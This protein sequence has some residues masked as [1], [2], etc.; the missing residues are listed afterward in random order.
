MK[1]TATAAR[2]VLCRDGAA[3]ALS[4][5]QTATR[6]D[7]RARVAAAG[8]AVAWRVD[9][10]R[11]GD[12][13]LQVTR[14]APARSLPLLLAPRP[15]GCSTRDVRQAQVSPCDS[16]AVSASAPALAGASC[17]GPAPGRWVTRT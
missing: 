3:L 15:S 1:L 14:C 8:G 2:Q 9:G 17:A 6:A 11:V 4:R 13:G 12:A 5:D 10:W 7:E 16:Q